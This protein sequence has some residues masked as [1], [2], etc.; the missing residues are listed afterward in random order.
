M[1]DLRTQLIHIASELPQGDDTKRKILVA[2]ADKDA[3]FS[4][5]FKPDIRGYM[6][7]SGGF[8]IFCGSKDVYSTDTYGDDTNMKC[9]NCGAAWSDTRKITAVD[10]DLDPDL[11]EPLK[12]RPKPGS[13][14]DKALK[15]YGDTP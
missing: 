13:A 11:S 7:D 9:G 8:C 12:E 4:T 14:V 6:R 15:A 5:L 2:L 1:S 10:V 3:G